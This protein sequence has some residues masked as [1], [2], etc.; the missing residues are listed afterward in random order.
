MILYAEQE[1]V[2]YYYSFL[3]EI[4]RIIDKLFNY[5]DVSRSRVVYRR[6]VVTCSVRIV[7][8]IVIWWVSGVIWVTCDIHFIRIK[9][10]TAYLSQTFYEKN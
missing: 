5:L 10:Y 3:S 8:T 2:Y 1:T 6:V 7:V 4:N 9:S